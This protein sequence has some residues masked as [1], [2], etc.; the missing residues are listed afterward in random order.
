M[1]KP[2]L[3]ESGAARKPANELSDEEHHRKRSDTIPDPASHPAPDRPGDWELCY[4][5]RY[6]KYVW[7]DLNH[8][9]RPQ[10]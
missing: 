9:H 3:D 7:C 6:G 2:P 4:S 1:T 8:V 10:G 5:E